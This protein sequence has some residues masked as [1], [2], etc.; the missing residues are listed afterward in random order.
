MKVNVPISSLNEFDPLTKL[1]VDEFYCGIDF[2]SSLYTT[3]R[4]ELPRANI[5]SA[6][7]LRTLV[8]K[9]KS[10]HIPL[11]VAL[12]KIFYTEEEFLKIINLV[13]NLVKIG[14]NGLMV[15][16]LSLIRYLFMNNFD[17][18][19]KIQLSSVATALN[20][21]A[22]DFY[23][24]YNFSRIILPRHLNLKE[25]EKIKRK[26]PNIELE[27]FIMNWNCVNID[28]LCNTQHD[29]K[30]FKPFYPQHT[31]DNACCLDYELKA[32]FECSN[33]NGTKNFCLKENNLKN[34][35]LKSGL[36]CGGC[37]IY[38]LKELGI[39][40]IKIEG[41]LLAK[42]EKIRSLKFI[43]E[44]L[45][46]LTDINNK[47]LYRANVKKIYKQLFGYECKKNCFYR[48]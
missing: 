8:K 29:L 42:E 33:Y 32:S 28:G 24:K 45:N 36:S 30:S 13:D 27:V 25:L 43:R 11:Y 21:K 1:G 19:I 23:R 34:I 48:K 5:T 26:H 18:K 12:N 16:D 14:I 7:E 40:N 10:K 41:R 9:C 22:I 4:R 31:L 46:L 38:D 44:C 17:N 2:N 15:A 3:N 20:S 37:F 6:N 35:V 39:E 47:G